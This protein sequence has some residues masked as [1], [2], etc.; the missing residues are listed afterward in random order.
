M[1]MDISYRQLA[2][3]S[4]SLNNLI[5]VEMLAKFAFRFSKV[6]KLLQEELKNLNEQKEELIRKYGD[7]IET[8]QG[9]GMQ[10]SQENSEKF[11]EEWN[12]V[13]D[14]TI[15]VSFSPIPISAIGNSNVTIADMALLEEFFLDDEEGIVSEVKEVKETTESTA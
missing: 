5:K 15:S 12:G 13:L 2:E 9:I 1:Q 14:E 6:A 4:G 7:E 11:F 8:E 3:M 10:V